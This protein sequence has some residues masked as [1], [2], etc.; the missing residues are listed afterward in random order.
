MNQKALWLH[1]WL[2]SENFAA[3]WPS[4]RGAV[5]RSVPWVLGQHYEIGKSVLMAKRNELVLR[6]IHRGHM[7]P[8]CRAQLHAIGAAVC[9][10]DS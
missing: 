9:V 2:Q 8:L 6:G 10:D 1:W 5:G 4:G 3:T 7:G